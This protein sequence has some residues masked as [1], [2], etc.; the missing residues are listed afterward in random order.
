MTEN[1]VKISLFYLENEDIQQKMDWKNS[2]FNVT[3]NFLALNFLVYKIKNLWGFQTV[4]VILYRVFM[5]TLKTLIV[6]FYPKE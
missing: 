6:T 1:L 5:H 3:M 4:F 2:K